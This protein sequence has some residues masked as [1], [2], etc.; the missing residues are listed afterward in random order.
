MNLLHDP[1]EENP[2]IKRK[3]NKARIQADNILQ[4]EGH[5]KC[6]G[7]CHELWNLQKKLLKKEGIDWKTPAEMNPEIDFE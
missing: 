6:M 4:L 5:I 1:Q 7:Y 2:A 3:I